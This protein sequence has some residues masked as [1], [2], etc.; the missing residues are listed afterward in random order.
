L[1][2]NTIKINNYI[3]YKYK[4]LN[5]KLNSDTL[6]ILKESYNDIDNRSLTNYKL[7]LENIITLQYADNSELT[8]FILK[9]D[10]E[11]I[12]EVVNKNWYALQYAHDN[13]KNDKEIVLAVVNYTEFHY[14][15]FDAINKK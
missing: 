10:K 9:Y 14:N 2:D 5:N 8:N 6:H 1:I 13:L 7:F 11:I 4:L 12:L 15:I 3:N